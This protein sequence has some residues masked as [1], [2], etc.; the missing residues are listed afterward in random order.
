MVWKGSSN[1]KQFS[2]TF[3]G[4]HEKKGRESVQLRMHGDV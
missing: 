4:E 2:R 1:L 3:Q